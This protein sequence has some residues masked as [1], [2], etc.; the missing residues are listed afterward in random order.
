VESAN[1]LDLISRTATAEGKNFVAFAVQ[2]LLSTYCG[3]CFQD[4]HKFHLPLLFAIPIGPSLL[5][6][7]YSGHCH[8]LIYKLLVLII[9]KLAALSWMVR[10]WLV[11]T[12]LFMNRHQH[13]ELC[14]TWLQ[15]G[16]P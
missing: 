11:C 15:I 16:T 3:R 14:W 10:R 13:L 7:T 6:C 8:K 4:H 2:E 1:L 12:E 5:S 9:A